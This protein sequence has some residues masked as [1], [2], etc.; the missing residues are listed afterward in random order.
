[1]KIK[2]EPIKCPLSTRFSRLPIFGTW[3][4]DPKNAPKTGTF[5]PQNGVGAKWGFIEAKT[6]RVEAKTG[7][8]EVVGA[9]RRVAPTWM[10]YGRQN[11]NRMDGCDLESGY[12]LHQGQRGVQNL[13]CG[14]RLS[15]AVP[16]SGVYGRADAP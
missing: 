7:G 15:P 2:R 12:G 11:K 5:L 4:N 13:L 9:T 6:A 16:W 14:A 8:V 3:E 1:M 10:E